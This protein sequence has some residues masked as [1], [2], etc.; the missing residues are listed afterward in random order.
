MEKI[1]GIF[2]ANDQ[3]WGTLVATLTIGFIH[4]KIQSPSG[5]ILKGGAKFASF[6]LLSTVIL[7]L[8]Y[9]QLI[10]IVLILLTAEIII[11]IERTYKDKNKQQS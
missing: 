10:K 4:Y 11:F 1:W 9:P 8:F 2:V 6:I 7:C 5:G 3:F